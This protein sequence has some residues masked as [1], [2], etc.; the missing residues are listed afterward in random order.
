MK[1]EGAETSVF[2]HVLGGSCLFK[3]EFFKLLLWII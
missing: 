1:G 2:G 3:I